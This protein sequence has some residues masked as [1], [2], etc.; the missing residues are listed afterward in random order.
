M[1][2]SSSTPAET[3]T[4]KCLQYS[5]IFVA[6]YELNLRSMWQILRVRLWKLEQKCLQYSCI[7]VVF[8]K[9]LYV[10][11]VYNIVCLYC[12]QYSCMFIAAQ[13]IHSM[14]PTVDPCDNF[15]E[16]ACGN[17][18]KKNVIPE[19]KS[20]Y[21]TFEKLH[22]ELQITLKGRSRS[23]QRS[24]SEKKCLPRGQVQL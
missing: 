5:C 13:L 9:F 3:G 6:A 1:T 11:S 15:F 8:T 22:D 21:N 16:Y 2:N 7:F 23:F 10:C 4:L 19:D 20:S 18:N 14:N 24:R 12:L 17:W